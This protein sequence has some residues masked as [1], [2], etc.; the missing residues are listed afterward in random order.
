MATVGDLLLDERSDGDAMKSVESVLVQHLL[1]EVLERL[2][3]L[4][5]S[6]SPDEWGRP[7]SAGKWSVHG[8]ALHLL[9]VELGQLSRQRDEFLAGY[10]RESEWSE[11]VRLL[12]EKNERWVEAASGLSPRVVIDVMR[13]AGDQ[14]CDYF[15]SLE[16]DVVG[17]TV[18]WAGNV[19]GS[20]WLHPAREYTERWHHQ[21]Q[22]REA[23]GRPLLDKPRLFAPVLAT[24][25]HGLP[26][27]Y[28]R[29]DADDG[30]TVR[31]SIAGDSGGNWLVHLQDGRWSLYADDDVPAQASITIGQDDAWRLFTRT[32]SPDDV[33]PRASIE[34]DTTL[35]LA[36]LDTVSI[37]A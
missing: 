22:I 10:I 33:R 21:P 28:E 4:L 12:N 26:R 3:V 9:D 6:L 2:L 18:D 5:E 16:P 32:L 23:T 35:A 15:A 31:V 25:V 13:F 37:I 30:T 27:A 14:A 36:A 34:G 20:T 7:T 29:V 24:F 1:P 17:P 8:V 19:P 11:L